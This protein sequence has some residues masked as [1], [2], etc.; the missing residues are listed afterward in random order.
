MTSVCT[1]KTT[2]KQPS[3]NSLAILILPNQCEM[4]QNPRKDVRVHSS[5]VPVTIPPEYT[6]SMC[7]AWLSG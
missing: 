4:T 1:L 2:Q 3:R 5:K 6:V 7:L